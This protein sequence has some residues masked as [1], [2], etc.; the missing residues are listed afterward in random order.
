MTVKKTTK[1]PQRT[2]TKTVKKVKPLNSCYYLQVIWEKNFIICL[3][4]PTDEEMPVNYG[5]PFVPPDEELEEAARQG[6]RRAQGEGKEEGELEGGWGS[7]KKH[8]EEDE[9]EDDQMGTVLLS[10][11]SVFFFFFFFG[12]CTLRLCAY[13]LFSRGGGGRGTAAAEEEAGRAEG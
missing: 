5:L 1:D 10:V 13:A 6:G 2:M 8:Y 11:S 7:R 4:H 12:T 9:I 3:I